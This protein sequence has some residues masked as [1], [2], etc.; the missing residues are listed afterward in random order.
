VHKL[1]DDFYKAKSL[2]GIGNTSN[3]GINQSLRKQIE[4]WIIASFHRQ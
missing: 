1:L 4:P 2:N 3:Q